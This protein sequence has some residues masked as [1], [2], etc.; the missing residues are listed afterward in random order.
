[1]IEDLQYHIL[2]CSAEQH[3]LNKQHVLSRIFKLLEFVLG[4]AKLKNTANKDS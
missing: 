2:L 1:M 3:V 4:D